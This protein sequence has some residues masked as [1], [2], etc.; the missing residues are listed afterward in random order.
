MKIT[1]LI[2]K[3]WSF[4]TRCII[5]RRILQCSNATKQDIVS[6]KKT[7]NPPDRFLSLEIDGVEEMTLSIHELIDTY[8]MDP[9]TAMLFFDDLVKANLKD[10]KTD[11]INLIERLQNGAHR[12]TLTISREMLDDIK[13]NQPELWAEFERL[14]NNF[15]QDVNED[16]YRRIEQTDLF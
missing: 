16:E 15:N 10:D 12:K 8:G 14:K 6:W 13:A 7:G 3:K 11:L 4:K 9:L 1:D 5:A 2:N